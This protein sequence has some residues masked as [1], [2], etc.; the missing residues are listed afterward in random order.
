[1]YRVIGVTMGDPSG[2]GPEVILKAFQQGSLGDDV[3]VVV[4]GSREVFLSQ[5]AMLSRKGGD[6]STMNKKIL[7]FKA[8]D[9]IDFENLGKEHLFII[10]V[11]D[12]IEHIDR[13]RSGEPSA[14]GAR[15]QLAA[16]M[17]AIEDAKRD[18]IDVIVTAPWTK[19]L[20]RLIGHPA[21][22]HTEVLAREFDVE[23]QVMM[24]AGQLLRVAL[25][26]T[27]V[28][29]K[30]VSKG[31]T[32]ER[33]EET[34]RTT[35][36]DLTRWFGIKRPHVAVAALNPHAGE[37]GVIG[38]EEDEVIRPTI[39]VLQKKLYDG[40]RVDGPF[41]ADTL[42]ARYGKEDEAPYDAVI[43]MYHDQALIPLKLLHF[44]QSANITLG[45]P[46]LRTSVDHGTAYDIAGQSIADEGSMRYAM[47][48]AVEILDGAAQ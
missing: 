26:T 6:Y 18:V 25:V 23:D 36:Q 30:D 41:A 20:F 27:H 28:P 12:G 37:H 16:L 40:V 15:L 47:Q 22:G 19:N 24:L 8:V 48:L 3:R 32:P 42:F 7:D 4:Y 14:A 11:S 17:Q 13:V 34:I 44:G 43:C 39:E 21:T 31:I 38:D 33:L 35:A 1:M 46:V 10:D 9:E 29:L 2:I 45:L 5:D